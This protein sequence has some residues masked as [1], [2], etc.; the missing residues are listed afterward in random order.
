MVLDKDASAPALMGLVDAERHAVQAD[1]SLLAD[2][3]DSTAE[4]EVPDRESEPEDG[5]IRRHPEQVEQVPEAV[6]EAGEHPTEELQ[7]REWRQAGK[8]GDERLAEL[9]HCLGWACRRWSVRFEATE[10]AP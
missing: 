8:P 9:G 10:D 7:V 5:S 6:A 2:R 1:G 4:G 3:R